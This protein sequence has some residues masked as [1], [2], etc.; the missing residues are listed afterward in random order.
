[1]IIG[2]GGLPNR[3]LATKAVSSKGSNVIWE[4]SFDKKGR[5]KTR[6][7]IWDEIIDIYTYSY[8]D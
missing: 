3:E 6:K 8:Y 4:Y 2:L 7:E 1:M 5:V